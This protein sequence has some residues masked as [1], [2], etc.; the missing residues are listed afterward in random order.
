VIQLEVKLDFHHYLE[1]E[2]WV[3]QLIDYLEVKLM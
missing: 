2:D 3:D 1:K